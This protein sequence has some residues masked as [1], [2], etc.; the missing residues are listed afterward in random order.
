MPAT[1]AIVR[2]TRK[3]PR[4]SSRVTGKRCR[5][6]SETGVPSRRDSPR[7][8]CNT[9]PSQFTYWTTSGS[10]RP[11]RSRIC[12]LACSEASG[13]RITVAGSPGMRVISDQHTT[14]TMNS[15]GSVSSRRRIRNATPGTPR[16][17]LLLLLLLAHASE[18]QDAVGVGLEALDG[19]L[20]GEVR[21]RVVV[22]EVEVGHVLVQDLHHLGV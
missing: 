22:E 15:I 8:P 5:I 18:P 14:L 20:H 13:P 6:S 10:L 16:S 11:S 9:L 4:A 19:W 17:P 12:S 3:V 21:G 7:S 2:L 1:T